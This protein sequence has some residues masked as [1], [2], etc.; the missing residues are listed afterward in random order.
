MRT[1]SRLEVFINNI[2]YVLMVGLGGVVIK[3]SLGSEPPA[4][5]AALAYFAYGI[6]GALWI[7]VFLCPSCA[8][9][10]TGNCP[11]GYGTLSAYL[12]KKADTRDFRRQF[13][14]HIPVIVPLWFIPPIVGG[15]AVARDFSWLL[16]GLLGAFV[17]DAFLFL[18]LFSKGHGCAECPQRE[19]CPWMG[20]SGGTHCRPQA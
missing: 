20:S 4:L 9:H 10:G 6:L 2:P 1:Y 17:L 5:A 19:N 7:I 14:K 3:I 16:V 18:P 12:R 8:Y 15:M 13:K 11:C